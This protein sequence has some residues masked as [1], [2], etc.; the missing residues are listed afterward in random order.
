MI[1]FP[2]SERLWNAASAAQWLEL[3]K[4]PQ[5]KIAGSWSENVEALLFGKPR[6]FDGLASLCLLVGLLIF[7]D[8]LQ[9]EAVLDSSEINQYVRRALDQWWT[10]HD[11]ASPENAAINHLCYPAAYYLRICLCIDARK[12]I[13]LFLANDFPTMR[14]LLR[15]GDLDQAASSATAALIP[16]VINRRNQSSMVAVPCGM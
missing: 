9:R 5:N 13:D 4:D 15:E 14:C 11:Q 8:E 12:T 6:P 2:Y 3:W 10:M 1:E 7:I 16:W